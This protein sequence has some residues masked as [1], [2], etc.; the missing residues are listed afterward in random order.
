MNTLARYLLVFL[1]GWS[2]A[3][4]S[5]SDIIYKKEAPSKK[6]EIPKQTNDISLPDSLKPK[7]EVISEPISREIQKDTAAKTINNKSPSKE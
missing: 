6:I 4:W 7:P 5:Y 3:V 1:L 2:G